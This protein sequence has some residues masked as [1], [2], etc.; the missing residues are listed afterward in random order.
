MFTW[1][2]FESKLGFRVQ[3]VEVPKLK[4]GLQYVGVYVAVLLL[5]ETTTDGC[6]VV[7]G[8]IG[9]IVNWYIGSYL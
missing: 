5:M 6:I 8:H 1:G 4:I 9:Y 2:G 7:Q 3:G